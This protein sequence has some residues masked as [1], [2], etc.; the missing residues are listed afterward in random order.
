MDLSS[1]LQAD[2]FSP[3]PV[4]GNS[5]LGFSSQFH[6]GTSIKQ[7]GWTKLDQISIVIILSKRREYIRQLE[8]KRL[9]FLLVPGRY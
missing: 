8:R 6:N 2:D 9:L 5:E 1:L 4:D 7:F 3:I